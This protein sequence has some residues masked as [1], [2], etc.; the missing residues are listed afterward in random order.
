MSP[1][2]PPPENFNHTPVCTANTL[3][4]TVKS[5]LKSFEKYAVDKLETKVVHLIN[6]LCFCCSVIITSISK[7]RIHEQFFTRDR[8]AIFRNYCVAMCGKIATRLHCEMARFA[9]R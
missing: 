7:L 4:E 9:D 5:Q 3:H 6:K 1:P 8:N 2:L